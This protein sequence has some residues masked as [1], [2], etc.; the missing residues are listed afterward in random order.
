MEDDLKWAI[1]IIVTV[2]VF[3]GG[4]LVGAFWKVVGMIK[5][6]RTKSSE[7]TKELHARIDRVR[8]ETVKKS[9]LDAHIMRLGSDIR[10]MRKEQQEASAATN[11]RLDALVA[12][13]S[14]RFRSGD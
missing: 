3:I 4:V 11:A 13:M 12:A 2:T 10:D 5:E 9:D 1:G 14:T 7:N 6:E 8:D